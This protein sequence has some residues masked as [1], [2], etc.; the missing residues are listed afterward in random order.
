M[1]KKLYEAQDAL[2]GRPDALGV[3]VVVLLPNG[4]GHQVGCGFHI[5]SGAEF[6]MLGALQVQQQMVQNALTA[7]ANAEAPK[8]KD[9]EIKN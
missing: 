6:P 8:S 4:A 3:F 2:L 5:R 1:I 7:R 9:F